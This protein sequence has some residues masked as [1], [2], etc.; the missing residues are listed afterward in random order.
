MNHE[1]AVKSLATERYLLGEMAGDERKA[2]E[3]HYLECPVCVE[4][5]TFADEFLSAGAEAGQH[6]RV[7]PEPGW[8]ERLVAWFKPLLNPLPALAT[9]AVLVASLGFNGWQAAR[10]RTDEKTIAQ[11]KAPREEYRFQIRGQSRSAAKV[12]VL[13]VPRQSQLRLEVEFTPD[14]RFSEYRAELK[15]ESGIVSSFRSDGK[16]NPIVVSVPAE[17]LRPG[18]YTIVVTGFGDRGIEK[19]AGD[20]I[21]DLQFTD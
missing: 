20:G 12:Q 21:F 11:L 19:E 9:I 10:V 5:V 8:R 7:Q 14:P 4:A 15:S 1:Q 13:R 2:F 6:Q 18:P 17:A 3:E 16:R